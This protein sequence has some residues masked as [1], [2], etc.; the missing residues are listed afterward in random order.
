MLQALIPQSL[1]VL[2]NVGQR[3]NEAARC[4]DKIQSLVSR[5]SASVAWAAVA[6]EIPLHEAA[7]IDMEINRLLFSNKSLAW[8]PEPFDDINFGLHDGNLLFDNVLADELEFH[9]W[10]PEWTM[11]MDGIL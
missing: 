5:V 10:A 8:N 2:S 7:E 3:W 4:V 1:Q 11:T 9:Q 6:D